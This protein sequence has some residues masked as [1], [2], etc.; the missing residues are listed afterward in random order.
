MALK[1]SEIFRSI[2]GEGELIGVPHTFVRLAGCNLKCRWCD[3]VYA[4]YRGTEMEEREIAAKVNTRHICITGGE[5]L[6]QDIYG[7]C[8]ML[9]RRGVIITVETNCTKFD[10]RLC[11]CVD[12]FS[13]SPKL[14]SSWEKYSKKV[15]RKYIDAYPE[16]KVN[17]KFV[18]QS[19]ND[20]KEVLDIVEENKDIRKKGIPVI[21]Q[22]EGFCSL[23]EYRKRIRTLIEKVLDEKTSKKLGGVNYR[24]LPQLHRIAWGMRRAR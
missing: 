7:L 17:L 23:P 20:L 3:T 13:V 19:E 4:R 14:G 2:Q 16:S 8:R 15:L 22:P 9:R 18:I 11:N 21:L 12:L 10:G 6:L 1:I 5:P 24:V